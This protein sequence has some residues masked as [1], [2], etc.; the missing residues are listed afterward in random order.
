MN[1]VNELE[2]ETPGDLLKNEEK[3]FK[4]LSVKNLVAICIASIP[5]LACFFVLRGFGHPL[6]GVLIWV[7]FGL[8]AYLLTTVILPPETY[9]YTGGGQYLYVVLIRKIYRRLTRQTYIKN[10]DLFTTKKEEEEG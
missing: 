4:Y 8:A 3:W 9:A 2:H 6:I 5:G 1:S 10:L 7:L